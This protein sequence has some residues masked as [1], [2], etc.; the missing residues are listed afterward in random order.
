VATHCAFCAFRTRRSSDLVAYPR[1]AT[2]SA[3]GVAT[4]RAGVAGTASS[5][6]PGADAEDRRTGTPV[7]ARPSSSA[8]RAEPTR[9]DRRPVQ[10]SEEHTSELQ[11]REKL[12]DC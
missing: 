11:S 8:V 5:T 10:R 1:A 3:P 4:T 9:T 2:G 6:P 7:N 12:V